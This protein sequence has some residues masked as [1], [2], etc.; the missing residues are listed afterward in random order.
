MTPSSATGDVLFSIAEITILCT[1]GFAANIW[2][3]YRF[4]LPLEK[5][6]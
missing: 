1:V 3:F 6:S 5:P 2:F 4:V